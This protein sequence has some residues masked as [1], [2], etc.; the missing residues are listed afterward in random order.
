MADE[1]AA[2][3]HGKAPLEERRSTG[4]EI[5][6]AIDLGWRVAALHALSPTTLQRPSEVTDDMLLNRRSLAPADRLELEVTAIAGVAKQLNVP[7]DHAEIARL[8]ALAQRAADTP[9]DEQ[10]FRD[11]LALRHTAFDKRLWTANE[12]SGKAYELGVFISD[13][14]NRVARPRVK[15]DP[16]AELVEVFNP[17]RVE[18]IKLL[19]DDLQA[20]V[21]PVAVHTV[22]N[23]L[24]AWS[25]RLSVVPPDVPGR[26]LE[27]QAAVAALEPV[28]RQTIIWRQLLTGDKE[29][30]A[31]IGQARR[32][33]V[34]DE[35]TKQLWKR[36]WRMA[37]LLPIVAAIG[38]LLG[39]EYAHNKDLAKSLAGGFFAITGALGLTRAAMIGTVKRG[40]QSWG[41]L[42]WNR[43]LAV[44][45]CRE[46]SLLHQVFPDTERRRGLAR[47]R[48]G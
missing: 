37:W 16:P 6:R 21:D 36:Y 9:A 46:T 20:R 31:F 25:K 32:G 30:E 7:L 14:W 35:L 44:V 42:M 5:K 19:L 3:M 15:D 11:E 43:A 10:A 28:E 26:G 8:V 24:S 27:A 22:T 33:E 17:V 18:R 47:L 29:P 34:R 41:D 45:I 2:E 12:Q 1:K 39:F 23:H 40:V 38:L 13:T 48:R 4:G